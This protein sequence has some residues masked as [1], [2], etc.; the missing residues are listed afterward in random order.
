MRLTLGRIPDPTPQLRTQHMRWQ[1]RDMMILYFASIPVVT[2][3]RI[4]GGLSGA[5]DQ[6]MSAL[7]NIKVLVLILLFRPAGGPYR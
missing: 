3:A 7:R 2:A 1:A 5:L 6:P 4:A